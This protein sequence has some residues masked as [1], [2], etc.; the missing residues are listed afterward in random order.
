MALK[1]KIVTFLLLFSSLTSL[2][3]KLPILLTKID[4]SKI[5][6]L[7]SD[8]KN[9]YYQNSDGTLFHASNY[10]VESILKKEEGSKFQAYISHHKQKALFSVDQSFLKSYSPIKEKALYI[11]DF[12]KNNPSFIANG[13]SPRLQLNDQWLSFFDA[14]NN[15][16][17]LQ[18][19][20]NRE[21]KHII[22]LAIHFNPYFIPVAL[23][24]DLN[25]ILYLDQDK[26]GYQYLKVFHL[27]KKESKNLYKT[28]SISRF[29]NLCLLNKT[30]FLGDFSLDPLS[31]GTAILSIDT[32]KSPL[33]FESNIYS[34]KQNDRGA[35]LCS[36]SQN[37]LYWIQKNKDKQTS[38][39]QYDPK[40]QKTKSID[41][42]EA[43]TNIFEMDQ[44]V[45]SLKNGK[46]HVI[47][48]DHD[49]TKQDLLLK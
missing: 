19:I 41:D 8:G 1:N 44:K 22:P 10:K 42:L 49:M 34:S 9:T 23:M 17:V 5:L 36:H 12:G 37:K 14:R 47:E 16:L 26:E 3:A 2:R 30:A 29:L 15:Q 4:V 6:Y 38:I 48:G 45:L 35:L 11:S 24:L 25:T 27:E 13:L 7:S 20:A 43:V 28:K 18:N 32:T 33:D 46:Y 21:L 39:L 40:T 31:E